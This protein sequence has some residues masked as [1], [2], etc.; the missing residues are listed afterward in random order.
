MPAAGT[1]S[2]TSPPA[3]SPPGGGGGLFSP[4]APGGLHPANAM[5]SHGPSPLAMSPPVTAV[6]D[7]M[8]D[9]EDDDVPVTPSAGGPKIKLTLKR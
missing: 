1:S 3:T 5:M 7:D 9:D 6:D 2:A 4:S 8:D